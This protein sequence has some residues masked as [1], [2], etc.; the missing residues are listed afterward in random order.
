MTAGPRTKLTGLILLGA[1]LAVTGNSAFAQTTT[2]AD[3]EALKKAA[4]A[5]EMARRAQQAKVSPSAQDRTHV[6]SLIAALK[7]KDP[8]VRSNAA[9]DLGKLRG[10]PTAVKPLMAALKD[11]NE[12]V[13]E[14]AAEALRNITGELLGE[15]PGEWQ[16]WWKVINDPT[17]TVKT[18]IGRLSETDIEVRQRAIW[19]LGL[20]RDPAALDPLLERFINLKGGPAGKEAIYESRADYSADLDAL[21]V[22]LVSMGEMTIEK[23][24]PVADLGRSD[25]EQRA[26]EILSRFGDAACAPAIRALEDPSSWRTRSGAA[27]VLQ[28]FRPLDAVVPLVK[29]SNDRQG[30]SQ[31]AFNALAGYG[32]EALPNLRLALKTPGLNRT[33][34]GVAAVMLVH[35]GDRS[36]WPILEKLVTEGSDQ[37]MNGVVSRMGHLKDRAFLPLI[38][39]ALERKDAWQGVTYAAAFCGGKDAT[40]MLQKALDHPNEGVRSGAK[41][42]LSKF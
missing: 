26:V 34:R 2:K 40:G 30:D 33:S 16:Q 21:Q 13:R 9:I 7:D 22:A 42:W 18:L 23:L 8:K 36:E 19:S 35:H 3:A 4:L 14:E 27:K 32:K 11:E 10:A 25:T 15:E 29:A 28:H 24:I 20:R 41:M 17:V 31:A 1:L 39:K 12:A 6:D 37:E 38:E 5:H